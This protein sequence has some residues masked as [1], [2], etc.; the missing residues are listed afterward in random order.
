LTGPS[1][2][3]EPPASERTFLGA[4]RP[5]K[6]PSKMTQAEMDAYVHDIVRDIIERYEQVKAD[7]S[8]GEDA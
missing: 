6:A 4:S 8:M 7:D 5:P 2:P 1:T 3:E